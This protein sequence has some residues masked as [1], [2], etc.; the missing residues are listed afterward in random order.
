MPAIYYLQISNKRYFFRL[1]H[2]Q[3]SSARIRIIDIYIPK[4]NLEFEISKN[5]SG[6]PERQTR[7]VTRNLS[8]KSKSHKKRIL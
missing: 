2:L 3:H 6:L 1:L 4:M 5:D 8:E 7:K